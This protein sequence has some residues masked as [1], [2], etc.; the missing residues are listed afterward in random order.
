MS[1]TAHPQMKYVKVGMT[2]TSFQ[3]SEPKLNNLPSL[4]SKSAAWNTARHK[5]K[6][7]DDYQSNAL[8]VLTEGVWTRGMLPLLPNDAA[9]GILKSLSSKHATITA[10]FTNRP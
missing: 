1:T 6:D 3:H 10:I 5:D 7:T 8:L 9:N 4:A 2:K